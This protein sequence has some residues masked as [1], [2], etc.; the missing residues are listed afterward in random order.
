MRC[1]RKSRS[2]ASR[3]GTTGGETNPEALSAG[4][5]RLPGR[6]KPALDGIERQIDADRDDI[7]VRC[8]EVGQRAL[9]HGDAMRSPTTNR[10]SGSHSTAP[11]R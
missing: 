1:S 6:A 11:I 2:T 9:L 10:G 4:Q 3:D 7:E 5:N 8:E